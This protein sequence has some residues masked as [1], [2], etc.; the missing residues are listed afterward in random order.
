MSR[1]ECVDIVCETR[2][3][4]VRLYGC[5]EAYKTS[6]MQVQDVGFLKSLKTSLT[7]L[8]KKYA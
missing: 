8:Y 3:I 5:E 6:I 1:L 7:E 4:T 2:Q